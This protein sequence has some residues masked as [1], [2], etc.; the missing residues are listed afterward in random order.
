MA[1]FEAAGFTVTP[2]LLAPP[3]LAALAAI[4]Q[5]L[6]AGAAGTRDLLA[7]P[8][9]AALARTLQT[10][11]LVAPLL[12]PAVVAVQC[13]LFEKSRDRNWLVPLHQ[14][15]SVPV[16]ER[17]EHPDLSG[18]S[19]KQGMMFVQAPDAL[20]AQMV[21]LRLHVDPCGEQD[22]PLRVVP[23][24]HRYGRLSEARILE[25][26]EL[27]GEASV[28]VDAGAAMLLR[29]LL[30]HASSKAGGTSRRRVLHL[31]FGPA[32]PPYGLAWPRY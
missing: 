30:L 11:P 32:A 24:S 14:D 13:T 8:A 17:V 19:T 10:H 22:G 12:P 1:Q 18:W 21:A 31:L 7:L 2:A 29:P 15:L 3:D 26:R 25:A 9:I 23:G 6:P 20:L 5:T 28:P 16:R 27:D 4:L